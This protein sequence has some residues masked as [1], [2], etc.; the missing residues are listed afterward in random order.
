VSLLILDNSCAV[1][2][3]LGAF[4]VEGSKRRIIEALRSLFLIILF[5]ER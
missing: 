4:S 5:P 3:G 1:P 2:G